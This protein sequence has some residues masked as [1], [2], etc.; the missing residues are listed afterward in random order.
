MASCSSVYSRRSS[1]YVCRGERR[2]MFPF[3]ATSDIVHCICWTS[4]TDMMSLSALRWHCFA[5][6]TASTVSTVLP[7]D[8]HLLNPLFSHLLT[9][10]ARVSP[11]PSNFRLILQTPCEDAS[12]VSTNTKL[13]QTIAV[14]F[15]CRSGPCRQTTKAGEQRRSQRSDIRKQTIP[16]RHRFTSSR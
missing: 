8:A 12:Q 11:L 3:A 14:T 15:L 5:A 10:L 6:I 4:M 16:E 1:A 2:S 9:L 7:D 13:L